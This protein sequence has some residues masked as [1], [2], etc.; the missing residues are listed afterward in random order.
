MLRVV[1][2]IMHTVC[3]LQREGELLSLIT[4]R[5]MY[6]VKQKGEVTYFNR[7]RKVQHASQLFIIL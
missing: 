2:R 4:I 6:L 5:L 1:E 7:W 3:T